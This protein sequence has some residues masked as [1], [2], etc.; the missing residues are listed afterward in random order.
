MQTGVRKYDNCHCHNSSCKHFKK[1][2]KAFNRCKLSWHF[3][4]MSYF[5]TAILKNLRRK[6]TTYLLLR[7]IDVALHLP[8]MKFTG[9]F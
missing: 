6:Y 9:R 1:S 3:R 2:L 8:S 5:C 4:K 7:E